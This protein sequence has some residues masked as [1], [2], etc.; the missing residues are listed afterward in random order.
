MITKA[1]LMC[2][3]RAY[4]KNIL[5]KRTCPQCGGEGYITLGRTTCYFC[6][7]YGQTPYGLCPYCRGTGRH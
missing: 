3:G 4:V 5:F 1:R 7:G 6:G 2:R